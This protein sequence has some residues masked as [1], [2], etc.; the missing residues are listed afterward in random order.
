MIISKTT[1][2]C[3]LA[4][5][6]TLSWTNFQNVH[7]DVVELAHGDILTGSINALNNQG[8]TLTSPLTPTPLQ[9][10][11]DT[12]QSITFN[13][14]AK[15]NKKHSEIITL[16]NGDTLPCDV[17]S[18]DQTTLQI[19]THYAGKFSIPR[20]TV[21]MLQFGIS[22][23]QVVYQGNDQPSVWP[24]HDGQWS[25]SK[26]GY[27][28]Q[29][30]GTL[31]RPLKLPQNMRINF[32]LRWRQTPNF[33]FR[34]CA[35]NTKATTN[36]NTYE[37][38]FNSAGLQIRRYLKNKKPTPIASFDLKPHTID[39][40][41]LN[42]DIRLNRDLG[43]ITLYLNGSKRG[44]WMD[45]F[46][47]A[48]GKHIILNN[49]ASQS[50]GFYVNNLK[51]SHWNNGSHPRHQEKMAK[52]ETDI[53]LDNEGDKRS[54]KII[55]I[56]QRSNKKLIVQMNDKFGTK[57]LKISE[58]RISTLYFT[59]KDEP[60][61]SPKAPYVARLLGGGSIQLPSP[62]LTEG[63]ITSIHPILGTC[64]LDTSVLS[65]I[66]INRPAK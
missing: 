38:S 23:E 11:P 28:C 19:N 8:I 27:S 15:D 64:S 45:T 36:Q 52:S 53:L 32:D 33:V 30:S 66:T 2:L 14:K 18:L 17:V 58:H 42:V 60:K 63:K 39:N 43:E 4:T 16:T 22:D 57:P 65:D 31:A 56:T 55:S 37:L 61:T 50:Q 48:E 51:V 24:T 59:S 12:I 44:S 6:T 1:S 40:Q 25:Y 3:V 21:K 54:G 41:Q 20:H 62:K 49:R 29:G 9:I 47:T 10:K 26:S 34:F 46:D 35:E 13:N 7:A 5:L